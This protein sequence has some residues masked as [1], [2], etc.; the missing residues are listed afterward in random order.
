MYDGSII[1]PRSRG[2]GG[3]AATATSPT[4]TSSRHVGTSHET[5]PDRY[6]PQSLG[7]VCGHK[8]QIAKLQLWLGGWNSNLKSDFTRPGKDGMGTFRAV[9]ISGPPGIGKTATARLCAAA[10]GFTPVE[11]NASDA[12]SKRMVDIQVNTSNMALDRWT[13]RAASTSTVGVASADRTCVIMDEVD[14]MSSGDRGGAAALAERIRS[15]KVP[16]ICIA[17]DR[18]AQNLK[19]LISASYNMVFSRPD[20]F[21]VRSRVLSILYRERVTVPVHVVEQLIQGAQSDV[22]QVLN[23]LQ[24]WT[25]L[26]HGMGT[27]EGRSAVATLERRP[28]MNPFGATHQL[29]GSRTSGTSSMDMLEADIDL[30][31]H[32][33]AMVPLFVQENY[34]KTTPDRLHAVVGPRKVV[35]H[36]ELMDKAARSLSDADIV[37]A[38]IHGSTQYWSLLPV[39]AVQS[40]VNPAS[41]VRGNGLGYTGPTAVSF[42]QWLGHNTRQIKLSRQLAEVQAKMRPSTAVDGAEFRLWYVPGTLPHLVRSLVMDG[43]RGIDSTIRFL[44]QYNLSREDWDAIVDVGVGDNASAI[45][46]KKI[47]TS[48]KTSFTKRYNSRTHRVRSRKAAA[49]SDLPGPPAHDKLYPDLEEIHSVSVELCMVAVGFHYAVQS[50]DDM[51]DDGDDRDANTPGSDAFILPPR[52]AAVA[53]RGGGVRSGRGRADRGHTARGRV[54]RGR[55]PRRGG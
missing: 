17:N 51:L 25:V 48:V 15:T 8:A 39:H 53:A 16:I 43:A 55:A 36:L 28:V 42:P 11:F 4:S 3:G 20:T 30:Y 41:L 32:D 35:E 52:I 13:V 23:I 49:R 14:G 2:P 26:K 21:A 5:W 6:A 1:A 38:K 12:R 54:A 9:M 10:A 19:P 27:E 22:R 33:P 37:D 44:E 34:L 40:T 47:P 29:L 18:G 45:V 31:F 7:D 24:M 46:L 50:D